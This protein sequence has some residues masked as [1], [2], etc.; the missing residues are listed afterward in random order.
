MLSHASAPQ[1]AGCC[2][3]TCIEVRVIFLYNMVFKRIKIRTFQVP[4][5]F[6]F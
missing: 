4:L 6:T 1:T 2:S 3:S 5:V